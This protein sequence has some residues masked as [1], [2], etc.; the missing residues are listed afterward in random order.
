MYI[1]ERRLPHLRKWIP[2]FGIL[3]QAEG[4]VMS[5]DL[6][7][8]DTVRFAHQTDGP[9]HRVAALPSINGIRMVELDDMPGQFGDHLFLHAYDRSN[10]S[11]RR[12]TLT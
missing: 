11:P 1:P 4:G 12:S 9:I 5:L 3:A 6:K 8:G 7:V 10:R 2:R